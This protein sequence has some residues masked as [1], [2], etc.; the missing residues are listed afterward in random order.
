[1]PEN[2]SRMINK[3]FMF[4]S[5][6]RWD[7]TRIFH[8]EAISLAKRYTIELHAPADFTFRELNNVKVVGLPLWEKVSDRK[9]I[10]KEI[11]DRIKKSDAD[12]FHFHDPELIWIGIKIKF[13]KKKKV[14]YDV[15]ENYSETIKTKYWIP[16]SARYIS[17]ILYRMIEVISEYI[18]DEL[19]LVIDDHQRYFRK[20]H[21]II[22]N[23]PILM[24]ND[25][26]E[27]KIYDAIYLGSVSKERGIFEIISAAQLL[28]QKNLNI[29]IAI[30]GPIDSEIHSDIVKNIRDK[31]IDNNVIL[32]GEMEFR[33]A[34][35]YVNKSKIGLV[36]LL[37]HKNYL[38]SIATKM[39]EYMAFQIPIIA[40]DFPSWRKIVS[41]TNCGICVNS[42]NPLEIA[43]AIQYLLDNE[44]KSKQMGMN[45]YYAVMHKY[46]WLNEEKKLF[47]LYDNI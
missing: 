33:Q 35:D 17:F 45:G 21:F 40:S 14:I 36:T 15:H 16:T 30:I 11:W 4:S 44:E 24:H 27:Q 41:D 37:P 13:F 5:V 7:D 23:F 22:K 12:I 10:R 34:L 32:Y 9:E 3:I 43:N 38:V 29:K 46:N 25:K 42:K 1:M 26:K 20:E 47:E 39:Y 28:V 6:H 18:F 19:I 8:K 31:Q 2:N